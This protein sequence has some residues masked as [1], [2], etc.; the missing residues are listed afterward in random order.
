MRPSRRDEWTSYRYYT[1]QDIV[2]LNTV[3]ALQLMDLP[4]QEI[5]RVLE[6]DDLEKIV[7]FLAQAEKRPMKK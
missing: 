2:R 5:K 4:L 7:A 6:Y 3:R 1:E